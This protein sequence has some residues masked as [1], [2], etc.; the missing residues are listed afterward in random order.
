VETIYFA[1][2]LKDVASLSLANRVLLTTYKTPVETATVQSIDEK[3]AV[4]DFNPWDFTGAS[5]TISANPRLWLPTR[6]DRSRAGPPTHSRHSV[7][8]WCNLV[9]TTRYSSLTAVE[10][11]KSNLSALPSSNQSFQMLFRR[12]VRRIELLMTGLAI[13][14]D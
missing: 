8:G 10:K 1:S 12:R 9:G 2:N 7:G 6:R 14:V 11:W 3:F 5:L 4:S 13:Q